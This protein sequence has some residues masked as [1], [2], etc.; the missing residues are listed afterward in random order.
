MANLQDGQLLCEH[1]TG[2]L[3]NLITKTGKQIDRD[4]PQIWDGFLH[5]ITNDEW[6]SIFMAFKQIVDDNK[7]LLT[8]HQQRKFDEAYMT[9]Q[10]DKV[11]RERCMDIRN[12]FMNTKTLA[13]GMIM[14]VREVV[15]QANK[16]DIPNVDKPKLPE[17]PPHKEGKKRRINITAKIEI[18]E[19]LF[20]VK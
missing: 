11:K 14:T 8:H 15:N 12:R 7:I 6:E 9:F 17:P 2:I 10:K 5:Q 3:N 18:W 13:W 20:D 1:I 19:D 4:E 16:V